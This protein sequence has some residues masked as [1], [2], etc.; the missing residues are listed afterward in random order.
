M[1]EIVVRHLEHVFVGAGNLPFGICETALDDVWRVCAAVDEAAA[2]LL[3]V[4]REKEDIDVADLER[5]VVWE[6]AHVVAHLRGTLHVNVEYHR[7]AF[8]EDF[9]DGG[10][11]GSVVVVV[12]LRVFDE[13]VFAYQLFEALFRLKVVVKAVFLFAARSARRARDRVDDVVVLLEEHVDE[14]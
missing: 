1:A 14:R 10:L 4:G 12:D 6:R 13:G 7:V 2:E 11:E 3:H 5:I 9:L 8:G